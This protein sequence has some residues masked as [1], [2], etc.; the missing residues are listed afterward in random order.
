MIFELTQDYQILVP[1]MIANMLSF[2]ISKHYQPKPV[3]HAL[4]EQ[5]HIH[6]PGPASRVPVGAW[7]ARD[8]MRRD[9]DVM[10]ISPESSVENAAKVARGNGTECLLVGDR[11]KLDGLVIGDDMEKAI[12]SG[13]GAAPVISI[14][15]QGWQHVHPDHPLE[16]ALQRLKKNPG[17]LPVLSRSHIQRVEGVITPE[18]LTEFLQRASEQDE[19]ERES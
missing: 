13:N 9:T 1:L 14:L 4:L 18:S 16:L 19:N 15:V 3:Y 8:I 2:M 17:L 12:R 7:R 6:L 11:E 10:F 5:D